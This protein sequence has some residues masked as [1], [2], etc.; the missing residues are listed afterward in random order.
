MAKAPTLTSVNSG[1]FSTSALNNNFT[2]ISEAFEN[3]LSI[4]GSTPNSMEADLDLDN[5]NLLN[6]G[7][8]NTSSLYVAGTKVVSSSAVPSWEGAWVTTTSY[9]VNDIVSES[10]NTYICVVAHTSGTFA[11]DLSASK[12]ELFASKGSSGGGTGDLVAANNLS[13]VAD[14]DTA[15][16]NLGGLTTGI[17]VFKDSSAADVRATISA[18]TQDDI[19]DDL[20][21]L[22]QAANKVPYF[23]TSTTAA[24]LDFLDEDNFVSDSATA[25]ASQQSIKAYVD[26]QLV[27]G[28]TFLVSTDLSNDSTA[29]FTAFSSSSYDSYMFQLNNVVPSSD[30]VT[31]RIRASTNNGSSFLSTSIYDY[32]IDGSERDFSSNDSTNVATGADGSSSWAITPTGVGSSSNEYGVSGQIYVNGPHLSKYTTMTGNTGYHDSADRIVISHVYGESR[33]TTAV[34]ALRFYYSTGNLESGTITMYGLKN[35]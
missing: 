27:G 30:G 32:A 13:D 3:T 19:L 2:A 5:N 7:Q 9:V 28:L 21:G 35:A 14:A 1:Y 16:A 25:L 8:I 18:Q 17:A 20:A 15:L 29:D 22:T 6:A 33:T 31:L 4:D 11:T 26:T 10:G 12:W 23:N 24:L 34:D